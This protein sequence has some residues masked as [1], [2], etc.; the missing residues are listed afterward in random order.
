M[1]SCSFNF[2][3]YADR[4]PQ[5]TEYFHLKVGDVEVGQ[6][7]ARVRYKVDSFSQQIH[8]AFI[9]HA[10]GDTWK[11]VEH[12]AQQ[13]CIPPQAFRVLKACFDSSPTSL[14]TSIRSAGCRRR[15]VSRERCG[16][17]SQQL[18]YKTVAAKAHPQSWH[19][20]KFGDFSCCRESHGC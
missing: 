2:S 8:V 19:P 4:R 1:R 12:C 14:R 6:T 11:K 7:E 5:T 18:A 13:F 9:L 20:A 10:A 15:C 3:V 16:K 17:R